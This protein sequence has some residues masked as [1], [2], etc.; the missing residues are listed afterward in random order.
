MD[1]FM[2][3]IL[4][5]MDGSDLILPFAISDVEI[6]NSHPPESQTLKRRIPDTII[7]RDFCSAYEGLKLDLLS[8]DLTAIGYSE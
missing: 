7:L 5:Q 6:L 3:C 1:D 2:T 8:T 4:L